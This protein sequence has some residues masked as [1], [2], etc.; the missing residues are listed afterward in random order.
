MT[1]GADPLWRINPHGAV[2]VR[3][4]KI[5]D[6]Y[7]K[8]KKGQSDLIAAVDGAWGL[9]KDLNYNGGIGGYLQEPS[10]KM[11]MVFSGPSNSKNAVETEVDAILYVIDWVIKL[12]LVQ[13]R[14]VIC[15]DSSVAV[16]AFNEGI[17]IKFPLKA[18]EFKHQFLINSK[19]FV[20]FVPRYLNE[21]ADDLAKKGMAR[22]I[23]K[24]QLVGSGNSGENP[25]V[26]QAA[27][28]SSC[29]C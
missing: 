11:V 4:Y 7:W 26:H 2:A 24:T 29:Q 17:Y 3:R 19:I 1:F 9:A 27:V 6:S 18:M 22:P 20:Q 14:T 8:F 5:L 21:Q 12:N 10:G 15:S 25:E 23:M 16:N 13:M 28:S